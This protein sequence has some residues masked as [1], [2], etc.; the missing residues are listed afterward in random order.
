MND[1][2]VRIAA[3]CC[4]CPDCPCANNGDGMCKCR[5]SDATSSTG[6][7]TSGC[8]C[9]ACAHESELLLSVKGM[10][11]ASCV[12]TVENALKDQSGISGVSVNL[13]GER[14]QVV[15]SPHIIQPEQ[16]I[17]LL[18]DVGFE[19]EPLKTS[20]KR[21]NSRRSAA[22]RQ[23]SLAILVLSDTTVQSVSIDKCTSKV[24][25]GIVFVEFCAKDVTIDDIRGQLP[26]GTVLQDV[27]AIDDVS[28][29]STSLHLTLHGGRDELRALLQ[30]FPESAVD[31]VLFGKQRAATV[32][33]FPHAIGARALVDCVQGVASFDPTVRE[34][35][36][37][38]TNLK[39]FLISLPWTCLILFLSL[40]ADYLE[41]SPVLGIALVL[42]AATILQFYCGMR[43]HKAA[44]NSVRTRHPT[45]DLLV[46]ASTTTGYIFAVVLIILRMEGIVTRKG[47]VVGD[48]SHD[49]TM[50]AVL[51]TVLLCGKYMED[52]VKRKTSLAMRNLRTEQRMVTIRVGEEEEEEVHASL[53]HIGDEVVLRPGNCSPCD[54]VVIEGACACD[55]ALL[56]G[57]SEPIKKTRGST[58]L[59]GSTIAD[60]YCVLRAREVGAGT[61]LS[62]IR[63]LMEEAQLE[64][65]KIQRVADAIAAVFVPVVLVITALTWVTWTIIVALH[66]V[67]FD[68]TVEAFLFVA[69]FGLSVMLIA[70]PCSFGLATPTAVMVASGVSAKSGCLVKSGR[71]F[72]AV[73]GIRH[74]VLDKTGTI[75]HGQPQVVDTQLVAEKVTLKRFNQVLASAE[76]YSEHPLGKMLTTL[77]DDPNLPVSDWLNITGKGIECLVEGRPVA[78][79]TLEPGRITT[80]SDSAT[81]ATLIG[82]TVDGELWGGVALRDSVKPEAR[83]VVRALRERRID[84]WMCT[85]D[86]VDAAHEVA[87]AVD[88]P[89]EFVRAKATPESKAELVASLGKALMVGDGINDS[90]A[91]A[92]AEIGIAIGSGNHITMDS[93]DVVLVQNN[94]RDL[95]S[96]IELSHRTVWTIYRNFCWAFGFNVLGIPLAAGVG[97]PF[98]VMIPPIAAGIAMAASSILVVTSSL[99]LYR[100]KWYK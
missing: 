62:Q 68:N 45:M 13:L 19:A 51:I 75:T 41:V 21:R 54:G 15:F 44:I 93:A 85:G 78:V 56:T 48:L 22:D 67:E 32:S 2:T 26:E 3:S 33:Y 20:A 43:F 79:K 81:G 11:C 57:E 92:K 63:R 87:R 80:W 38:N 40:T 30:T 86:S 8:V 24:D 72:E 84:V 29:Y 50:S 59:E 12:A 6:I 95:Q 28:G 91:L 42:P 94:L 73:R 96:F 16:I 55:E 18:Q 49:M 61:T 74:V 70:C 98:G 89:L 39:M 34:S 60:G 58:V 1:M 83:A 82:L 5:S 4:N 65:T 97:Y 17:E 31:G 27:R 52:Y 23:L 66:A 69:R 76:R 47:S 99:Q 9:I 77:S 64:P 53:L 36:E 35:T 90:I 14:A 46:S 37:T 10:T 71:T 88:I 100:F 7:A 25:S